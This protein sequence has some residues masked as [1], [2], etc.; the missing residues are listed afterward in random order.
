MYQDSLPPRLQR[1]IYNFSLLYK[2]KE[3]TRIYQM[4]LR[5]QEE[6]P[7]LDVDDFDDSTTVAS[8]DSD[9]FDDV[10]DD[11]VDVFPD[12]EQIMLSG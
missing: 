4:Q 5:A 1:I 7:D 11:Y 12:L 8:D 6:C 2:L 9:G 10:D 3:E